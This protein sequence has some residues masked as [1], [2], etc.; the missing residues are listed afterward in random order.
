MPQLIGAA[1]VSSAVGAT[2]IGATVVYGSITV[3]TIAGAVTGLAISGAQA[4]R[5]QKKM[6]RA[7]RDRNE[8][9]MQDARLTIRSAISERKLVLGEAVVSGPLFP[10]F[11]WGDVGQYHI[12]AVTLAGHECDSVPQYLFNDEPVTLD[13]SGYVTTAKWCKKVTHVAEET[14]TLTGLNGEATIAHTPIGGADSVVFTRYIDPDNTDIQYLTYTGT[15]VAGG[16]SNSGKTGQVTYSWVETVPLFRIRTYLG[17]PGQA[18][19]AELIAGAAAAGTPSSWDSTRRGTETCYC[20]VEFEADN[21]VLGQTGVPSLSALV[22][23]VMP[24]DP[25]TGL[26]VWSRNP[27]LLARWFLVESRYSPTTTAAEVNE[28]W[29]E[30]SANIADEP[31]EFAAGDTRP[32]YEANGVLSTSTNP[33]EN[34]NQIL[35][36]GDADA[37][38][39]GGAWIIAAGAYYEPILTIDEDADGGSDISIAIETPIASAYNT[40]T[41]SYPDRLAYGEPV[42]YPAVTVAGYVADDNGEELQTVADF[43]LVDD[44]LRCQM[45]AWQ[46]L[47]RDRQELRT[48]ISTNLRGYDAHPLANVNLHQAE[49]YGAPNKVFKVKRREFD[50]KMLRYSLQEIGPAVFD[51][52]YSYATN[53]AYV[54]IPNTALPDPITLPAPVITAIDSG[55]AEL[56][57]PNQDGTLLSR[58]KLT[59]AATTNPYVVNGGFIETRLR[60]FDAIDWRPGSAAAPGSDEFVWL[61]PVIDGVLYFIQARYRNNVGRLSPWS[62]V[63]GHTVIG[64]TEVPPPFDMFRVLVQPDG[65]RQYE[66]AYTTTAKPRDWLGAEI[67]YLPGF[68]TTPAWADMI[69]F[70]DPETYYTQ[71]PVESN[72]LLAGEY[73]FACRSI[74]TSNNGSTLLYDQIELPG[75]RLGDVVAEY[76][77]AG[78]G[79]PG[80]CTDCSVYVL[81]NIIVADNGDT[82]ATHATWG[83]WSAWNSDPASPIEYLTVVRDLG[84]VVTG[85]LDASLAAL[86]VPVVE[87]RYS[88]TSN[89][90]IADPSDWSAWQDASLQFTGRYFQLRVEITADGGNPIPTITGLSYLVSAPLVREYINDLDISTLTGSYRIGTGDIRVPL[91]NT[92]TYLLR[93]GVIIQ[94]ASAG[95]WS[96]QMVDKDLTFGPRVQ[97]KLN[98][99]LADPDLVDFNPEGF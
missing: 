70:S 45:I 58:I 83:A 99:T 87:L 62:A 50:G 26:S 42:S 39:V 64:K 4:S 36:A 31:V 13:G 57:G 11:T 86:G 30:A 7:A 2:A 3:A 54:G 8:A 32:R 94:D 19:A 80:T 41:G 23:G 9:Q 44:P 78:A 1:I 40:V 16:F 91:E 22:R 52:H 29:L 48:D 28:D 90:P 49:F 72:Q 60:P 59:I 21:D 12:Y 89:D 82:W 79:W 68:V 74:D 69:D 20:T 5:Q 24:Y 67:R 56:L 43:T 37:V 47:A 25:R 6:V 35:D 46:R 33:L 66:F 95:T 85:L 61:Q 63:V 53:P 97:F 98:G 76:D 84:T 96:W 65:T 75:R 51:W 14:I 93:M 77:E 71:S 92:Y 81:E 55:D 88:L 15:T 17:A 34:L 38:W 10:W 73:T 18:A 27:F